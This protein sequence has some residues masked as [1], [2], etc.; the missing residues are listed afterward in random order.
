MVGVVALGR[1]CFSFNEQR[2][3][4]LSGELFRVTED[5]RRLGEEVFGVRIDFRVNSVSS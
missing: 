1:D 3:T 5:I 4:S 2:A